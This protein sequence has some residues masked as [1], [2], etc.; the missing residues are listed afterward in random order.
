MIRIEV[1]SITIKRITE[2]E[3]IDFNPASVTLVQASAL[4]TVPIDGCLLIVEMVIIVA[5]IF[6][7][8]GA[9]TYVR[10]GV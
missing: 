1:I 3:P 10:N 4:M 7:I 5:M 2:R 8:M 9:P 6:K